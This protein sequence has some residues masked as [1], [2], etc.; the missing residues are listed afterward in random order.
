[1]KESCR[2]NLASYSGLE[3]YA[4]NGNITGVASARGNA[5]QPS[6]SEITTS[7]CRSCPVLEKAISSRP[8]FGE[9]AADAAESENLC[10]CRHSKRENREIL[11][12]SELIDSERSENVSDG[13]ADM[14]A[15]RK[16]DDSIVPA[17][18]ANK[19][20]TL[21]AELVEERGSP[22]GNT[23]QKA[24]PRT[25]CHNGRSIGWTV[26]GKYSECEFTR[27]SYPREEPYEIML[28]VR[29]CAGS[30]PQGPF[31]P[32]FV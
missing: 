4:G 1:M 29:I 12:V 30:G 5:G 24:L 11:L 7:V 27:P 32:R 3:P 25:Q 6:S 31:L 14:N 23:N 28:H 18:W 2:E 8:L 17:K 10:M 15:N 19:T 21:V 9:A 26:Y 13:N 22:K 20:R 16:S